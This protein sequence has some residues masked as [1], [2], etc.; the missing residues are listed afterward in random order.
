MPE[1]RETNKVSSLIAP[2]Y[3]LKAISMI[4]YKE[5][6]NNREEGIG[7]RQLSVSGDRNL[8]L[9]MDMCIGWNLRHL[10]KLW[11]GSRGRT[12]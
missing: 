8:G 5:E 9:N 12:L 6:N 7:Q 10:S 4:R 2:A 11:A 3:R 1:R